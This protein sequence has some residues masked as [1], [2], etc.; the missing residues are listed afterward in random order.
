[1]ILVAAERARDFPQ[2]L[3]LAT[4]CLLGTGEIVETPMLSQMEDFHLRAFRVAGPRAFAEDSIRHM[5]HL[6]INDAFS[7]LPIYGLEDLGFV[8][9]GEAGAFI[10]EC[11]TATLPPAADCHSTPMAVASPT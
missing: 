2:K 10:A 11:D 9:R 5:R 8:P 3:P 7:H 6:M 1:L 4:V